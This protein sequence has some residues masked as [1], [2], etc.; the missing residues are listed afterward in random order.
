MTTNTRTLAQIAY[1]R[2]EAILNE[3]IEAL[4]KELGLTEHKITFGYIGNET[5]GPK[6]WDLSNVLWMIFLPHPGRVG[7]S[8]DSL[9]GFKTGSLE[10]IVA[11]RR[12]LKDF[13]RGAAFARSF[14]RNL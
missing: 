14:E 10:G 5:F 3:E 7:N 2:Q 6:G 13:A 12:A 8:D 1:A 9:G 11:A 4:N